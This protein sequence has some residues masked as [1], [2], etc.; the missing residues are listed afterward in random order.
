M[1]TDEA[2]ENVDLPPAKEPD[3][4]TS[5]AE[6]LGRHRDPSLTRPATKKTER[7]PGR[8]VGVDETVRSA[9]QTGSRLAG[10]GIDFQAELARR[11]RRLSAQP[12]ARS[13]TRS[14]NARAGCH[15]CRRSEPENRTSTDGAF[16]DRC[17]VN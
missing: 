10:R 12:A 5:D 4:D 14:V 7:K 6:E 17:E 16:R 3:I 13:R 2:P 15:R 1:S 11:A 9:A 8:G